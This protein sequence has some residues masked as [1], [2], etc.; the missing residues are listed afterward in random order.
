MR[1]AKLVGCSN[2]YKGETSAS[3]NFSLIVN[4]VASDIYQ[5]FH[6][7]HIPVYDTSHFFQ[8]WSLTIT[9]RLRSRHDKTRG[10][11]FDFTLKKVSAQYAEEEDVDSVSVTLNSYVVNQEYTRLYTH[12]CKSKTISEHALLGAGLKLCFRPANFTFDM[13]L[14]DQNL[15]RVIADKLYNMSAAV[16][17][18]LFGPGGG[19]SSAGSTANLQQQIRMITTPGPASSQPQQPQPASPAP[20]GADLAYSSDEEE[21]DSSQSAVS[22]R[23]AKKSKK[24]KNWFFKYVVRTGC[25]VVTACVGIAWMGLQM[26][27]VVAPMAGNHT[28]SMNKT[29]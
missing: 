1:L 18:V 7:R 15:T 26:Y 24:K 5:A 6:G 14:L 2:V 22:H 12:Y 23:K 10:P 29:N 28:H 13:C 16:G 25:S 17:G 20:S 11:V 21:D 4:E 27:N 8:D 3:N 19:G 9:Y